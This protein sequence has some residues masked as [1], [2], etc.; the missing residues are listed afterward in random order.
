MPAETNVER[1]DWTPDAIRDSVIEALSE[2]SEPAAVSSIDDA[3]RLDS[4]G[5]DGIGLVNVIDQLAAE[6]GERASVDIDGSEIDECTTV[7]DLV[8]LC[9]SAMGVSQSA[10][11]ER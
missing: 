11:A 1:G 10:K 9:C 3:T 7:G 6:L 8:N 4:L 5:L 2:S